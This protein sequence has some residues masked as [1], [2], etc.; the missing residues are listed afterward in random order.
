VFNYSRKKIF[1][2]SVY[3]LL[4]CNFLLNFKA[5]PQNK[6]VRFETLSLQ[7]GVSLNL[8]WAMLQDSRGYIWFGTMYG[9]VK[10]DGKNYTTYRNNPMDSTSISFDDIITLFEDSRGNIWVGT[11]GGGLNKF[12]PNTEKFTR[13]LYEK[14]SDKGLC[15]NI[16]WAINE[17]DSGDIWIGTQRGG[18]DKYDV[19]TKK[20][21][22]YWNNGGANNSL[23]S[24]TVTEI[25]KDKQG[26]MW[27]GTLA[28]L[29]K[30]LPGSDSFEVFKNSIKPD[31]S[32]EANKIHYIFGENENKLWIG[33]A[34]GLFVFNKLTNKFSLFSSNKKN[35]LNHYYI[36]SICKGN[37]NDVWVGTGDG[38]VRVNNEN[39]ESVE[40]FHHQFGSSNSLAGNT[41]TALMM[42]KSGVL[43]ID[44]YRAGVSKLIN[45]SK[46]FINYTYD[47]NNKNSLGTPIVTFFA[48]DDKG[49][50]WISGYSSILTRYHPRTNSFKRFPLVL[51]GKKRD[52]KFYI[53]SVIK[54][55]DD[56][57]LIGTTRGILLFNLTTESQKSLPKEMSKIT[58]MVNGNI[59]YLL[60]SSDRKLWAGVNERGVYSFDLKNFSYKHFVN[61]MTDLT[62]YMKNIVQVIYEDK[63]KN[64]WLGTLGG[65][66]KLDKATGKFQSFSHNLS[67]PESLSNNYVYYL[68]EDSKN[69]FWI[70][71]SNG[72]NKM[73]KKNKTFESYFEENGLPNSV[74]MSVLED[75]NGNLW[76]S[77]NK[78]IARFDPEN[79]TFKNFDVNDGLLTNI[80]YP[81]SAFIGR[82]SMFYFGGNG[83]F[84]K[85]DPDK[86][87]L[88]NYV[89]PVYITKVKA[90]KDIGDLHLL[91]PSNDK[92]QLSF[93][94]NFL[95]LSFASL[96]YT[97]PEKNVYKYKL[98]GIDDDWIYSGNNNVASYTDLSPG[99]YTFQVLGS[100]SDGIWNEKPASIE[101][102]ILPPF[103]RTWWFTSLVIIIGFITI[104]LVHL[105]WVQHKIKRALEIEKIRAEES[106]RV[107]K[108]TA[109]DFHDELGHRLTR[110]SLL[111]EIVK[112]KLGNSYND[113]L[114]LLKKISENSVQLYDGTK[115]FIWA[116]DP[117]ND[118]LYELLVRLKD[119]GDEIFTDTNVDF[120]VKGITTELEKTSLST[121]MKR[122]LSLIFKEG[123][124]NSL[125]HSGSRTVSLESKIVGDQIEITLEDDGTGFKIEEDKGGNGLKNMIRRAEK[126][127]GQLQINTAPGKGTRIS[128]KGK[129]SA[130]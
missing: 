115:D 40:V 73:D 94:E 58:E 76:V 28:G 84:T 20:F 88:N 90:G 54:K 15:D 21:I 71:T 38:L 91:N 57:L 11:W 67:D 53:S 24:N 130:K 41:I 72:L 99:S 19:K 52:T 4:F 51:L 29:A 32:K 22:H 34:S 85:F 63:N 65:L 116:I 117:Q 25:Y 39:T 60:I 109:I 3:I 97:N 77:T 13:F 119:F 105:I 89:S 112:R 10:Y 49:Y 78:G 113:I 82:N 81:Q 62:N 64:I 83:G 66:L 27:I 2:R 74:I 108:Q 44:A 55:D 79:N 43:W 35:L 17:D 125:K 50:I 124:N 121:D 7:N 37:S 5:F 61:P 26:I 129:V 16:V 18:I 96:D 12:N 128:F 14:S 9:L 114:P 102:V 75:D 127:H 30:Y 110:I 59:T 126:I 80:F 48:Q 45:T 104:Y 95:Q 92:L 70:G 87:N 6:S 47:P 31:K 100:N 98:I 42:D 33:T 106:E 86:I 123:M 118:S 56:N 68:F 36:S 1:L 122:H 69:N 120:L 107:R 101:I 23:P 46:D 8:T 93:N 103:W 111:T